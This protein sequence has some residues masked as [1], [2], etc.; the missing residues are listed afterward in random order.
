VLHPEEANASEIIKRIFPESRKFPPSVKKVKIRAGFHKR[1]VRIDV[2]EGIIAHQTRE[3]DGN[4]H[5][6]HQSGHLGELFAVVG[7]RSGSRVTGGLSARGLANVA[8]RDWF[9]DFTF[10]VGNHRY[11]C[12]SS[13]APLL[14]PRVSK[15]HSIED[16]I[17]EIRIDVEDRDELFGTVLEGAQ[18]GGIAVD[19]VHRG[20]FMAICAAL[21]KSAL[22]VF[23][24]DQQRDD[25][26]MDK[27]LDRLRFRSANRCDISAK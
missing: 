2:P 15:L 3:Y 23:D 17:D 25:F 13:L 10:I 1:E 26:T 12:P 18:G 21:W 19:S 16:T 6:R 14:S 11:R 22:C 20:T 7:L 4:V 9:D 27:E 24:C 8:V 5:D